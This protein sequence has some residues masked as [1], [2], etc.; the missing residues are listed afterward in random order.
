MI[1]YI[2]NSK[3]YAVIITIMFNEWLN[4]VFAKTANKDTKPDQFFQ[5]LRR[6]L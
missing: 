6:E 2:L 5:T 1:I 3:N 4:I